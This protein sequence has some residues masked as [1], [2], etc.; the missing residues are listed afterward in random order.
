[1]ASLAGAWIAVVAGFGGLRDHDGVLSFN[2][3]LPEGLTRLA[4]S[5]R[6][7]DVRLRVDVDHEEAT[8]TVHDGPDASLTLRHAGEEVEVTV[9]RPATRRVERRQPLL[10]R[11][12]QPPGREPARA[13]RTPFPVAA[14]RA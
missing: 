1:M 12:S 11:P 5:V 10:P 8:Y 9:D 3:A 14:Q 6:W 4:F 7:R 2:P 13:H